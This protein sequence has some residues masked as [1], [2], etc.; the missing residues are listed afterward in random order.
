M[1]HRLG[2]SLSASESSLI[3]MPFSPYGLTWNTN[4]QAFLNHLT[5]LIALSTAS[6]LPFLSLLL[7]FLSRHSAKSY[8]ALQTPLLPALIQFCLA[9]TSSAAVSIA[10]KCLTIFLVT[11]PVIIGPHLFG[12]MA[13]YGRIVSWDRIEG[14]ETSEG[15]EMGSRGKGGLPFE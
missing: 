5:P 4:S 1:S 3:S 8:H 12:I 9:S 10:V 6:H 14:R 2:F 7:L 11:L 15:D 13:V